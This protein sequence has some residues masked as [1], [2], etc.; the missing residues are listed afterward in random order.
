M[1]NV[2]TRFAPSP[3][4]WLH[5]GGART[6]LFNYLLAR[7]LGGTFLLRIEDTD[8][9]RHDESAVGKIIDDL[10]WL[11]IE[12][13]EGIDIDAGGE[14]VAKGDNGPYRQSERL[15]KYEG[16]VDQLVVE[17]KAYYAFDT[18]EELDVLRKEAE[19]QKKSFR[20]QRPDVLPTWEDLDEARANGRPVVVRFMCPDHDVTIIDAVFG[21]VTIPAGELDDFVIMKADGYPVYHMANVVDDHEMGVTLICRGQ[22][23]LGQ[24][25]RQHA[26][27]EALGLRQMRYAHL[28]LI[29]DMKGRKLS[30]RDGD[31]ELNSFRQ[32]GYLPETMVNFLV[33]LGWNPGT[34]QE[35]FT[36][37]ELPGLIGVSGIGDKWDRIDGVGKSNAKFDRDKLLAFSTRDLAEADDARL[38]AG[39]TDF[40]AASDAAIPADDEDLLKTLLAGNKGMRTFEDIVRKTGVLFAADDSYDFDEK[41]VAKVLAKNDGAGL[42]VLAKLRAALAECEFSHDA[43]DTLITSFCETNELGMGKVAQPLRVAVTGSTISPGIHETLMILGKEKTLARIDRCLGELTG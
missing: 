16:Y 23:F 30:K 34:E 11:G 36:L 28:P 31:V 41:A 4:G 40:L 18:A 22:E 9:A 43:L 17:G 12:W 33:L 1:D 39:F 24:T 27:R 25:W 20:Y 42:A 8:R 14:I 15:E 2:K 3:T 32:A 29:M 10:K 13:D 19:A 26:L 21:Y 6:A 37:A 5:V 35:R 38:L 7:K